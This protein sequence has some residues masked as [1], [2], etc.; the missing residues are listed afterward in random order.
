MELH[1]GFIWPPVF[2]GWVVIG[3][4]YGV[5]AFSWLVILI[6]VVPRSAQMRASLSQLG[7]CVQLL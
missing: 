7:R 5:V 1:I 3:V 6:N 4:L 2:C